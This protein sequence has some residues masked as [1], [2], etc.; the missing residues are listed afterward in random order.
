MWPFK[1]KEKKPAEPDPNM[2]MIQQF[3]AWRGVGGKFDY[4]GR[5]MVVTGHY[6]VSGGYPF[7]LYLRPCLHADYADDN[8]VIRHA[9]FSARET[10]ALIDAQP[11]SQDNPRP[12]GASD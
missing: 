7:G 8:G 12:E 6:E 3:E 10:L 11:N 5:R 4:L 2:A 9:T 1:K